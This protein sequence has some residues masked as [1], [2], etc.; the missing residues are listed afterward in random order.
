MGIFHILICMKKQKQ[1]TKRFSSLPLVETCSM[2]L[3]EI[4][5]YRQNKILFVLTQRIAVMLK[6]EGQD[7]KSQYI[8]PIFL[9][10]ETIPCK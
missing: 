2:I 5:A 10:E 4:I 9:G 6:E 7:T 3:L 1:E 8:C